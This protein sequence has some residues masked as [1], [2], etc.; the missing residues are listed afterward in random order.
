M[1]ILDVW[2]G[3]SSMDHVARFVLPMEDALSKAAEELE[4][5]FLVNLRKDASFGPNQ[6]FDRRVGGMA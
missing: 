1:I 6:S 3:P 2:G 5:G 4:A